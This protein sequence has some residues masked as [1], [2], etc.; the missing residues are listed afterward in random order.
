MMTRSLLVASLFS[1]LLVNTAQAAFVT[2]QFSGVVTNSP[3][4]G[5]A[6]GTVLTGS[7][8]FDA[9]QPDQ[10]PGSSTL[11]SYDF[12]SGS[13]S[14]GGSTFQMT[15]RDHPSL[16]I[17]ET[18]SIKVDTG[19]T[20][21]VAESYTVAAELDGGPIDGYTLNTMSFGATSSPDYFT[22]LCL[23][24]GGFCFTRSRV[25]DD[26]Q[27]VVDEL[28]LGDFESSFFS[29][30]LSSAS[31]GAL[32]TGTLDTLA[33]SAVPLPAAVWLFGSALLGLGVARRR[34]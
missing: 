19:T 7:Y 13:V 5:L 3:V 20:S 32:V 22:P 14:I 30:E 18:G 6:S 24:V 33:P 29:L 34:R 2:M 26:D 10:R 4:S 8:T 17:G 9:L 12:V 21:F 27:L 25:L 28:P 1:T 11:G 31:G 23:P 16:F 15:P